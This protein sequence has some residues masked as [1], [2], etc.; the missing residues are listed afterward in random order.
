MR[1]LLPVVRTHIDDLLVRSSRIIRRSFRSS[2][3]PR[4]G[5]YEGILQD[6]GG[7]CE[8]SIVRRSS[9]C[10][11][12]Y[13][14]SLTTI[15]CYSLFWYNTSYAHHF[16]P[17]TWNTISASLWP[18]KRGHLDPRQNRIRIFDKPD[19]ATSD[20]TSIDKRGEQI[21]FCSDRL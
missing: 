8:P 21:V 18:S 2:M 14:R 7:F 4:R 13:T 16:L 6:V 17:N 19:R 11:G 20:L 3:S 9:I 10:A 15:P 5:R 1:C 12:N